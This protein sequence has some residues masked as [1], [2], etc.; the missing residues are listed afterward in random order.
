MNS[1]ARVALYCAWLALIVAVGWGVAR[2]LK[3]SSDLRDFVPPARSA[4]QKLLLDEIGKGPG[5]RLLLLAISGAPRARLA[6]LSR[7]LDDALAHDP[8]FAHV[9]NGGSDLAEV[10]SDLLPYRYLLSPT[11]DTH[12]FDAAYLRAQLQQ[13]VEDLSSPA[14]SLLEP[15]LRRDPTLET[16]KLAQLWAPQRQPKL[17]DGVWFSERGEALLVAETRAA[18]FDPG[19]QAAAIAS[20]QEHFAALPGAAGAKLAISGPGWFGVE[21]SRNTRA[22]ADRFGAITTV[23]FVIMLLLAYR[24]AVPVLVTALPLLSGAVVGFA[25]LALV[26]GHA[27]GITVAFGFTLLGVAQEYPLRVFSHRRIGVDTATCVRELWPLLAT[28]IASVCIAYLAFF[29]S[30]VAGLQQLAV[31]TIGGLVT[32][33]ACTRW[34]LPRVVPPA[35]RDMAATPGLAT[36]WHFLARLPRPRWLPWLVAVAGCAV[37]VLAPGGFWQNDLSALTPI[38]TAELQRDARLRAALGAPDVRYLLVLRAK[39]A[40]GVLALSERV[41]PRLRKLVADHA[42]DGFEL[43]SRYL[44]SVATQRARQSRLPDRGDLEASLQQAMQ[45]LPFRAGVFAPFVADVEAARTLP[46]LTPAGFEQSPLG[47]RLESMLVRQGD[48]WVGLGALSGVNDPAAFAQ[49][50]RD[51]HGAAHLL[52]LKASTESLV[53]AYRHRILVALGVA[54]LLL[55]AAVTLALRSPR[56]ALHVLG[57]MTLATLLVL[58]VLR[59]AGIPL[60]LFHLVSLTLAAGLGLHYALFFERRTGDE[61]EDLRTLHAT[62]VCVASALL[63]FGV[64]ALSSVPVLRAIGLTVALGVA[65]HF[66]LSVLMAPAAHLRALDGSLPDSSARAES[67]TGPDPASPNPAPKRGA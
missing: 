66:T 46:P 8:G 2:H 32:A 67:G 18:G 47:T 56:R 21:A 41:A 52:D 40:Q 24:S 39:D 37:V 14:A 44:P 36:A 35:R 27:H 51:T 30:G 19:A 17:A 57:P 1:G 63:V 13:R 45:D 61:R 15:W 65:F 50:S 4:D 53:V 33:G 48:G 7:G 64:L 60:S 11:L 54:A 22:E 25:L 49:L 59:G 12:R 5:S 62:L 10:A 58:V 23:G 6:E 38:P 34:L 28:A 3:I 42:V 16:L 20:L 43:P 29:A 31:F 26:F 55:C 9:A